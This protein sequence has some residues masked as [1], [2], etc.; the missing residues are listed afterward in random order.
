MDDAMI[1]FD[2]EE[3]GKLRVVENGGDAWF[4]AADA[5][6]A[7][8]IKNPTEAIARLD[9][10]E[11][12][13]LNLGLRGGRTN[14]VTFP[15]LLSL[16]LGSR[17][18]EA[19]AYKRWVTHEVLPSVH[20]SGG[21]QEVVHV[22]FQRQV[23]DAVEDSGYGYLVALK[24]LCENLGVDFSSQ[25]RRLKDQPWSTVVMITTVGFDG[26]SRQ[27]AAVDRQTLVNAFLAERAA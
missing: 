21:E 7:L 2:N 22:P 26:R 18:P 6:R 17:K 9:D 19:K 5:C 3:F 4:V 27:M 11:K 20:E 10:D 13:R 25:L 12:A 16:I 14:M 8:D 1:T 24:P 23:I 15:G